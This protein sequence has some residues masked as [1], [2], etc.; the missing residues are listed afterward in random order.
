MSV[1]GILFVK[2]TLAVAG[3]AAVMSVTAR[4]RY[5]CNNSSIM[6]ECLGFQVIGSP[7]TLSFALPSVRCWLF[8]AP[9]TRKLPSNSCLN[10]GASLVSPAKSCRG[11]P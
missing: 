11:T 9:A 2:I 8:G 1:T 4:G 10:T 6:C 7:A 5:W 3:S